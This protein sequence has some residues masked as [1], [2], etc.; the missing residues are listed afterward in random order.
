MAMTAE[1][2][3]KSSKFRANRADREHAKDKESGQKPMGQKAQAHE[4]DKPEPEQESP[5]EE[6]GEEMV[7]PDIHEE[8]KQIAAEHGPAHTLHMTHDHE[9]QMSHVHSIHMDGHEHHAQHDG[10][11]HVMH[12]QKHGM[13]A[14]GVAPEEEHPDKEESQHM[15]VHEPAD[16]EESGYGEPL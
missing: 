6:A 2:K 10:P 7:H 1:G 5:A 12:A 9:G 3:H 13:H 14:A 4:M 11:E 16:N 8:I 15:N